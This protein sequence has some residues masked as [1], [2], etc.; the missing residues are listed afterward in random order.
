[1]DDAAVTIFLHDGSKSAGHLENAGFVGG[2]GEI[3]LFVGHV[4]DVIV[5]G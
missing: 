2:D 1:M 5:F 4:D 3:P